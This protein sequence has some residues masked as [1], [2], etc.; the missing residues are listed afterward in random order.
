M[1]HYTQSDAARVKGC[2][3]HS[4][5]GGVSRGELSLVKLPGLPGRYISSKDLAAFRPITS[6]GQPRKKSSGPLR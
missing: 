5:R 2:S 1:K 6:P 4:I 3:L